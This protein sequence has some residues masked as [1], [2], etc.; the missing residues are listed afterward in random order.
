MR[1]R[2]DI[3]EKLIAEA[4]QL[5][6]IKTKTQV[7]TTA[8]EQ[9][10]RKTKIAGIKQYKGKVNLGIDMDEIRGRDVDNY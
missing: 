3:P 2:L 9:L 7:I 4:M 10:V 6:D 5:T 1:A 8:L